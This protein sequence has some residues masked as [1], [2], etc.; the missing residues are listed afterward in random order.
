LSCDD[1]SLAETIHFGSIKF[2]T[3]RFGGLS[4]NPMGG[5]SDT[6]VMGFARGGP[7]SPQRP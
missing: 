1:F 7:P 5:S 4:L 2:I 6:V 3:D